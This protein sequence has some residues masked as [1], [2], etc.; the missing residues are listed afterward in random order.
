MHARD[1]FF[2]MDLTRRKVSGTLSELVGAS[3]LASDVQTRTLGLRRASWATLNAMSDD[4]RG[5]LKAY[6]NG[7]NFWLS[8]QPLPPEYGALQLSRADPWTPLDTVIV[9]KALAFQLSFDL[10]IDRTIQ[11]GAFQQTIASQFPISFPRQ[12]PARA[13]P[14]RH[15]RL[16]TARSHRACRRLPLP[17]QIRRRSWSTTIR[18]RWRSPTAR[19]SPTSISLHRI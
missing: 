16:R 9:G 10:D 13:V 12:A 8:T 5:W 7:V 19:R 15:R 4:S 6:A 17:Q 1:R 14:P 18:W 11:F 3:Q 2:Q